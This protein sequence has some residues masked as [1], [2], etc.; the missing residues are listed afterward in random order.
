MSIIPEWDE[1]RDDSLDEWED[2]QC[3]ECGEVGDD[4]VCED[5]EWDEE[6]DEEI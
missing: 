6:R 4:C 2:D 5:E 3:L 1:E